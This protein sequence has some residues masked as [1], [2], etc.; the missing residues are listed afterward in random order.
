MRAEDIDRNE[1]AVRRRYSR[2]RG[3]CSNDD[4]PLGLRVSFGARCLLLLLL[5]LRR[6]R[7]STALLCLGTGMRKRAE[8]W[9]RRRHRRKGPG[10]YIGGR[11]HEYGHGVRDA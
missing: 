2:F 4:W 11:Q 6:R 8:G 3:R 10:G 7:R 9:I 1:I 5:L